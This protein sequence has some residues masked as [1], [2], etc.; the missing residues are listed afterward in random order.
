MEINDKATFEAFAAA[1][2]KSE[3]IKPRKIVHSRPVVIADEKWLEKHF[4]KG[5]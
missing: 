2:E 5:K 4:G 1:I 3:K